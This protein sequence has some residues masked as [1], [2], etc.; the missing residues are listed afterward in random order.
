MAAVSSFPVFLSS[1]TVHTAQAVRILLLPFDIITSQTL[2][3]TDTTGKTYADI[4]RYNS[5]SFSIFITKYILVSAVDDHRFSLT[6]Q[7]K[8]KTSCISMI[9]VCL[10]NTPQ[11]TLLVRLQAQ[12][13]TEER[14]W[15]IFFCEAD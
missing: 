8:S 12:Q 5:L 14:K 4:H 2:L 1:N 9:C 10:T 15:T 13:K 6:E 3:G 11:I 7:L